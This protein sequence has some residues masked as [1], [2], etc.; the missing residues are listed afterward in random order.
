GLA[1]GAPPSA[2]LAGEV[3]RALGPL[4]FAPQARPF[5]PHLTLGRVRAAS[6]GDDW[7]QVERA[8]AA[9]AWP[10]AEVSRFTLWRS[11]L[12]PGG[13]QYQ[14]LAEFPARAPQGLGG[15]W[16]VRKMETGQEDSLL[17]RVVEKG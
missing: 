15:A 14:P 8:V 6:P 13:P 3:E 5:A 2:R 11:V 9:E 4:G 16:R 10:E 7:G 17:P 1:Q 12:G